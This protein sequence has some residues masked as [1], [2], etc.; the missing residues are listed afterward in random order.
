[1][2]TANSIDRELSLQESA[3][4]QSYSIDLLLRRAEVLPTL[5]AGILMGANDGESYETLV[6][7]IQNLHLNITEFAQSAHDLQIP[8]IEIV[9]HPE[10]TTIEMLCEQKNQ[11]ELA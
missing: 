6:R 4:A 8:G 9:L 1:M 5:S 7:Q 11:S 3:D 10:L 2:A